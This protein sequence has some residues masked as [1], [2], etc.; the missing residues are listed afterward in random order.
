MIILGTSH[1]RSS[2]QGKAGTETISNFATVTA[3]SLVGAVTGA[4]TG[5]V[6]GA[7][8]KATSYV[9]LGSTAYIFSGAVSTNSASIIAAASPLVSVASL[10]GSL[11]LS[12]N[13]GAGEA[14]IFVSSILATTL[15]TG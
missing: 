2:L 15:T 14:W 11:Y 1:Y 6:A 7:I 5:D 9:K 8:V 4:V 10:P 3:D 12:Q 13:S